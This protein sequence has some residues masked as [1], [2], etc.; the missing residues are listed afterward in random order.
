MMD[1]VTRKREYA[2]E[3]SAS[4]MSRPGAGTP[5]PAA[6][7]PMADNVSIVTNPDGKVVV[8]KMFTSMPEAM[9][10][11]QEQLGGHPAMEPEPAEA[12]EDMA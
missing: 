2:A 3:E 12:S 11:V 1:P 5:P 10:F 4:M 8:S 9:A 7:A 6:A